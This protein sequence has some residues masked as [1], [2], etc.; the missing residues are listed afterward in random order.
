M[1]PFEA[2][3][4]GIIQGLTEFLPVSSSGHLKLAQH[5]FG[6]KGL[7]NFIVFDLICHLGTLC[8][9]FLLLK[10]EIIDLFKKDSTRRW[11]IFLGTLPLFP[12]VFIMKPIKLIFNHPEYLGFCFLITS[13]LLYLGLRLG[14]TQTIRSPQRDALIIGTFQALAIFPGI[15]RSGATIS[16]AR[17]LGWKMEEAVTF[18]FMLAIP[19]I[20]GG[21]VLE[22][23]QLIQ[24]P[25]R[26]H[27]I[28]PLQYFLAFITSF[29]V[30][31]YSLNLLRNLASKQRFM[32][33]VWY[34]LGLGIF[35]IIYF[36]FYKNG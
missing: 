34:C 23:A 18:S 32:Y 17:L 8:A 29:A 15:S 35:T 6:F 19:A 10:K 12:L 25:E 7:E 28:A 33:F 16:S 30:G 2:I 3:I 24:H 22:T 5:L 21:V 1:S 31:Y 9:I 20:L 26:V 4:L 36:N 11:Q 27:H 13:F 14:Q